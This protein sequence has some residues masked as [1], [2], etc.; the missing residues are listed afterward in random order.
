MNELTFWE[1]DFAIRIF[2]IDPASLGF[3]GPFYSIKSVKADLVKIPSVKF[4]NSQGEHE[5]GI[6]YCLSNIYDDFERMNEVM[7]QDTGKR[8]YIESGYR[9]P[10]RQAYLFIKYL[11]NDNG[12]SLEENAKWIAMPGYSEH[13]HFSN[14]A[15]D[16]VNEDGINGFSK[17]QTASD[18]ENLTEYK[19]LLERASEFNF[20]ISYPRNNQLGVEFE[21]WHWHWIRISSLDINSYRNK[22]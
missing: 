12:Y 21:P 16:F 6:Q 1:K 5:T 20:Y 22:K 9:S 14:H 10:G 17:G 8:L 7:K 18:F 19:W 4:E 3:K 15:I 13:G 11:V 2:N